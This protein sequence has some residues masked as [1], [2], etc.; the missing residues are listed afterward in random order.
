MYSFTN[1]LIMEGL[2]KLY[3]AGGEILQAAGFYLLVCDETLP[4]RWPNVV[5]AGPTLWQHLV[6]FRHVGET[7]YNNTG[8]TLASRFYASAV[9]FP[10]SLFPSSLVYSLHAGQAP[11]S[12]PIPINAGELYKSTNRGDFRD[13]TPPPPE[14]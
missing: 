11:A 14:I 6:E 3:K 1:A 12:Q 10:H 13:A 2:S 7:P 9:P 5:D 8:W 4:Q